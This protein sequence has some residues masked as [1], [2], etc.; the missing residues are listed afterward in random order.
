V[1]T[2][3]RPEFINRL[4]EVIMFNALSAEDLAAIL[5]LQLKGETKL[6]AERGL[7]LEFTDKAQQWMLAQNDEP[8]YGARPLKRI[9]RRFVREPLADFLLKANPPAGTVVRVDAARG[10]NAGLKFAALVD[11]KEVK[12]EN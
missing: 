3:F 7:T 8:Q 11:G 12:V 1:R 5:K 6:A 9:I 2:F 10:K 4:D